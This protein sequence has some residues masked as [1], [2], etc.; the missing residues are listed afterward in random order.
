MT[1]LAIDAVGI[2]HS[3]GATVLLNFLAS[4][5]N[6]SRI[7]R[8]IVF[9]SP[10]ATRR[11][12]LPA[13]P[14]LHVMEQPLAERSYVARIWWSQVSLAKRAQKID[15]DVLFC[16]TGLGR[17][18]SGPP[19]VTFVQQSLP[20]SREVLKS[21][22]FREQVRLRLMKALMRSSCVSASRVVV[23][24]PTMRAWLVEQLG[25]PLKRIDVV[26]PAI[27]WTY[28]HVSTQELALKPDRHPALL[29]V[30]SHSHHKNVETIMDGLKILHVSLPEVTLYL[31]WPMD[32]QA[33]KQP[34]VVCLGFLGLDQLVAA[35]RQAD[36]LV[37]P[38]LVETVG[39]PMLEAMS[40]GLPVLAADRPYAHDICKDAAL[41]FD[42][43]SSD[44]FAAKSI[45]ILQDSALR[46]DF[47]AK[48]QAR[49]ASLTDARPY[50][51]MVDIVL[52]QV[53]A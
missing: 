4:A 22:T 38:S 39:L 16:M 51:Q 10:R 27:S 11:F 12:D 35:Y 13:S 42:P 19:L 17:V 43:L 30:G 50:M 48:G 49:S 18:R 46:N 34:G 26:L 44:D 40:L 23:Q 7:S 3:G 29:Y 24:T 28:P 20:F 52:S 33:C 37:M 5:L 47:A 8:I 9:C 45:Q 32:H 21:A 41:F 1:H 15:A 25:L 2:K 53:Q 36:V 14:R 31:T 6:D